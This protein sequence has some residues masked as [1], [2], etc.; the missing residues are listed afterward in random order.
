MRKALLPLLLV[1]PLIAVALATPATAAPGV[2]GKPLK[3]L[4]SDGA[5]VRVDKKANTVAI[6]NDTT[7][8]GNN[9]GCFTDLAVVAGD[10][11]T[12]SHTSTVCGGGVPRLFIRF[13]DGTSDNTHDE[14]LINC[15]VAVGSTLGTQTYSF[16]VTGTITAF[17]FINDA[18][19]GTVTYSNLV[20]DGNV[21]DF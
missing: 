20:I 6:F 13:A 10:I 14:N 7:T 9:F 3:C 15:T 21:I 16:E 17:A 1:T 4:A 8:G 18:G 2:P 12:F 5:D 19:V 11:I